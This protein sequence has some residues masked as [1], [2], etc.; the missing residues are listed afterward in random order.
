VQTE[1]I[2]MK[3]LII[4]PWISYRGAETV[5]VEQCLALNKLGHPSKIACLFL[6]ERLPTNAKKI[7]YVLPSSFW[8]MLISKSRILFFIFGFP[9][10]TY[11]VLKERSKFDVLN[12]HN[13]PS[14]WTAQIVK[15]MTGK[16]IVWTLHN[17][18]WGQSAVLVDKIITPTKKMADI[19]F[20]TYGKKAEVVYNGI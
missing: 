14:L 8:Q 20:K 11:I 7:S 1:N 2:N 4:Q 19:A 9:V 18:F 13:P 15:L 17:L 6:D 3:I 12:P 5:S 16:K 10:L